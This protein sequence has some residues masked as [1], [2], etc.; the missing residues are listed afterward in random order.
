[1]ELVVAGRLTSVYYTFRTK[2]GS[3]SETVMCNAG[4]TVVTGPTAVLF[5]SFG[6]LMRF[7]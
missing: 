4:V 3:L 1:M 7:S 2:F 6:V 5:N